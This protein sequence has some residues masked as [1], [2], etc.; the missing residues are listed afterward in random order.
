[1]NDPVVYVV[2]DDADLLPALVEVI[3]GSGWPARG[4]SDAEAMLAALQPDWNGV[5]L[6]DMR[7]PGMTG[8][9][10][11][12][13]A[14]EQAPEVPFILFTAHGDI[15]TAVQ[16]I[17]GGAFNFLEKTSP[18]DYLREILRRALE[19]RRLNLENRQLRARISSGD[20]LKSRLPGKSQVMRDLRREIA[21]VAGL[22]VAVLLSGEPGTGKAV[23]A[24]AI[25]DNADRGG[26][27][28]VLDC[29]AL[30]DISIEAALLGDGAALGALAQAAGGTLYLARI[31]A[32]S[33]AAQAQLVGLLDGIGPDGPRLVASVEGGIAK[34]RSDGMLDDDLYYRLSLAEIELPPLRQR[35][36]DVFLLLAQF[37][38]E[39]ATRHRREIPQPPAQDLRAYRRYHWP[40]NLRELRNVA[41]KLVIGLRVTLQPDAEGD[42]PLAPD[43]L[44][45][46]AA[47]EEFESALLQAALQKT[48]GRKAEAAEAL[49]IPRKRL[50]LR[51]K[52][53]GLLDS[54]QN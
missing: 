38:R 11:L 48:G 6:S 21:A 51:M 1:M 20:S 29:G 3:E 24:Q 49:G 42:A 32:L 30:K 47:M 8:L 50:Y 39:A 37:L 17:R 14:Q 33:H 22:D 12:E 13:R 28:V 5:I 2:D 52:A 18:S 16:A 23:A 45:Y 10:L 46:D 53:C 44:G 9:Q 41:E 15:P 35:D 7:M 19:S 4:F 25:H 31:A 43:A 34:L 26:D 27:Y 40:G 36:D 54:G